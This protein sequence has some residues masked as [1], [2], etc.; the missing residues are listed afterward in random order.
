[1]KRR[2]FIATGGSVLGLLA[3][4]T[5]A[6]GLLLHKLNRIKSLFADSRD[7][8]EGPSPISLFSR[9]P[10]LSLK[11]PWISL[12]AFPTPVE[13]MPDISGLAK[14][15]LWVKR[16]D[17]TSSLYGGNKLRKME[18]LL[19][20]AISKDKNSLITIGGLGS[21][22]ALA[23][24]IHGQK[25]GF[26]V[27]LCLFDQ[28]MNNYVK[29]NL[30]GFLAAEAIIH[31]C[32][33]MKAA[34]AYARKLSKSLIRDGE[35]PYFILSGGTCGLSNVGHV[36]AAME[37]ADQVQTGQM[38]EP[39]SLYVAAGTCGTISGL[40]A[41]LKISGLETRVVGI[42]VVD[43]FPA[44]PY[45]IRYYAQKVADGLRKLDPSVPGVRIEKS[46]FDLLTGHLGGGYGI[47]TKEGQEAVDRVYPHLQLETTYTGKALAACLKDCQNAAPDKHI[48]FWNSYNSAPFMQAPSLESLPSQIL[49]KLDL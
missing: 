49:Q 26:K 41:G 19:A 25:L 22:H 4:G 12:G 8:S 39:D 45:I 6:T 46:D 11:V 23:T 34:Y 32:R 20:D 36:N 2:Q 21:N 37:L 5:G 3:A 15:M 47:P 43:S 16:D 27:H 7:P 13:L 28:P 9:F 48:L 1:V 31:Y 18:H 40:I 24:A 29:R 35:A 30:S 42:R 33:N 10:E 44:Y 14:G 38:P 17:L